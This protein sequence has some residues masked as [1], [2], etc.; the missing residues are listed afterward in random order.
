[1]SIAEKLTTI[2]ENEQKIYDKGRSDGESAMWNN[3]QNDGNRTNYRNGFSYWQKPEYI[4][5]LH[6]VKP[7]AD[8]PDLFFHCENIKKIEAEFFDLSSATTSNNANSAGH[9]RTFNSCYELVE[10]EDIGMRAGGLYQTF[11]NCYKLRKIAKWRVN[12]NCV[13]STPFNGC[14]ALEEIED[15][16]GTIGKNLPISFSPLLTQGTVDRIIDHL[17]NLTGQTAQTVTFH[18]TVSDNLTDE[19][20]TKIINKNWNVG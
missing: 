18:S 16:E 8:L 10:I 4:R 19:Q 5:P 15:I 7:T 6:K 1:M 2:A 17:A 13:F 14:N 9:Y 12:E 20:Y 3:I 11:M